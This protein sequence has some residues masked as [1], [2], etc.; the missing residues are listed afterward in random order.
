MKDNNLRIVGN[1]GELLALDFIVNKGFTIIEHNYR[2][3]RL[4]EIDI[5]AQKENL[6]VFI[7]VK[8]RFSKRFGGALYSIGPKKRNRILKTAKKFIA[9]KD[10][11]FTKETIFRFDLITIENNTIT[12]LEDIIRH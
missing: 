9:A 3:G 11:L 7:E 5:I 6:I 4:G 10:K 1:N 12:W 2:F 8:T